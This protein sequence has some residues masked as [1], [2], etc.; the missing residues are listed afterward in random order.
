MKNE[1][2]NSKKQPAKAISGQYISD[3]GF[4]RTLLAGAVF[5]SIL[6]EGNN[7][8]S[9]EA[10][11]QHAKSKTEYALSQSSPE[12]LVGVIVEMK[13]AKSGITNMEIRSSAQEAVPHSGCINASGGK[14]VDVVV[15]PS[16]VFHPE[17]GVMVVLEKQLSPDVT[18]LSPG[19]CVSISGDKLRQI[20]PSSDEDRIE[21]SSAVKKPSRMERMEAL[22]I[23]I[24]PILTA[25]TTPRPAGHLQPTR[26][27]SSAFSERQPA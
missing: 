11:E 10:T 7:A 9:A 21:I 13:T 17:Q 20:D 14:I 25:G 4:F 6:W 8:P 1:R 27:P 12:T 23:R 2:S 5:L 15:D 24:E 18:K 3:T 26:L 16:V 22:K 19:E